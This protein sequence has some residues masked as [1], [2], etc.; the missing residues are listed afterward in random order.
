[1][2]RGG[3][4]SFGQV[5]CHSLILVA[6]GITFIAQGFSVREYVINGPR[7][8]SLMLAR[9]VMALDKWGIAWIMIGTLV[10]L[11]AHWP[12]MARTWGYTLLTGWCIGWGLFY[13]M[14]SPFVDRPL[15][16]G[17]AHGIFWLAQGFIWWAVSGLPDVVATRNA[18][19][20]LWIGSRKS[21]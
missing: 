20:P 8:E 16:A 1:M 10:F 5:T 4:W 11:F 6:A 17:M 18:R 3:N 12:N 15:A 13:I 14:G 2:S 21:D 19:M 9:D 7:W